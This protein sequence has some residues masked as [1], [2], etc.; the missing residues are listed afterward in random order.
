MRALRKHFVHMV[1]RV[2]STSLY[3]NECL[4][5]PA[6]VAVIARGYLTGL[7]GVVLVGYFASM[8]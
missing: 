2:A 5:L 1:V 6:K 3:I 4:F 8:K 7:F